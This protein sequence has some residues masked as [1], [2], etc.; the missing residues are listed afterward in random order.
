M[1]R[2]T[3][4]HPTG[5]ELEILKLL[6]DRGPMTVALVR[7]ELQRV[8]DASLAHTSVM[9]VMGTMFEK[10]YLRRSRQGNKY[11]YEAAVSRGATTQEML[12]DLIGRAFDGAA[13]SV[14]LHLLRDSDLEPR[15]LKELQSLIE[16]HRQE[17]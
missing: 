8:V 12:R 17:G 2:P 14:A 15:Q 5:R 10:G 7:A 1:T 4:R 11:I 13:A 3:S 16:R 6:W 9:T